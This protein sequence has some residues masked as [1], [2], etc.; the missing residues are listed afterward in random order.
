MEIQWKSHSLI[1]P[2]WRICLVEPWRPGCEVDRRKR[3][4]DK[5]GSRMT[6]GRA[7]APPP[8][9]KRPQATGRRGRVLA[10]AA[11]AKPG[12]GL[13]VL[14]VVMGQV[15]AAVLQ[16]MVQLGGR[17]RG[18]RRRLRSNREG[19]VVVEVGGRRRR[20]E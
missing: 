19:L 11:T 2:T 5:A 12:A 17:G 20:M 6:A 4:A 15:G 9:V 13:I 1:V 8:Q 10:R 18:G 7:A 14:V 16:V 3:M